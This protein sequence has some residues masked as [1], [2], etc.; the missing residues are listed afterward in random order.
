MSISLCPWSLASSLPFFLQFG[1]PG[2]S[3][4]AGEPAKNPSYVSV[5]WGAAALPWLSVLVEH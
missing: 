2:D 1:K 3:G 4:A 5:L